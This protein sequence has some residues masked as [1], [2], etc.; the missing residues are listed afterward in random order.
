MSDAPVSASFS[1]LGTT[2][3]VVV[4]EPTALPAAEE[5]LRLWLDEVDA[6]CSRFRPTS[7]LVRVNARSGSPVPVSPLLARFLRFALDAAQMS[8]G[9]VD[10]TLGTQLQAVGYDRTF[11]LVR[12]R[13]TWRIAPAS[14]RRPTWQS[15]EL[16]DARCVLR[17]PPGAQLD[18]GATAKALAADEAARAI[19]E[20]CGTGVL[21]SLG[22]DLAVAGPAPVGGW[23]VLIADDHATPTG[24]GGP[25]VTIST[26]GLATSSTAVRRWRTDAGEAH[27]IL[28]PRT[29]LPAVSP[30]RT[31]S[32]AAAS[33]GVANVASTTA[34]ILG[35]PALEWLAERRFPARCV[36][37]DGTVVASGGWPEE[38]RAA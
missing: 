30:W 8:G 36:R 12:E 29:C 24:T 33:C 7:E 26:G 37:Q 22:G 14:T 27:H 1:A 10:P 3:T 19:A 23:P 13:T 4:V 15:V 9:L 21:V 25:T 11:A 2:A 17:V 32:V 35:E 38:S 31:V 16:D 5:Q 20:S 6:A 28:D 18:L 34:I